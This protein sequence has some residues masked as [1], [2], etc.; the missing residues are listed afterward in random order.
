MGFQLSLW[1]T[2]HKAE[3][4]RPPRE[5]AQ[6]IAYATLRASR[7]RLGAQAWQTSSSSPSKPAG[8]GPEK[9][10]PT[11]YVEELGFGLLSILGSCCES[12]SRFVST[13][14][15]RAHG[16]RSLVRG[17]AT[18]ASRP[19]HTP[20]RRPAAPG[21]ARS[22]SSARSIMVLAALPRPAHR[23]RGLHIDND[24]V[25]RSIR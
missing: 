24:G 7:H 21:R 5:A 9:Q 17:P 13:C 20:S 11:D 2:D 23:G 12:R 4:L 22:R 18:P 19:N 6:I 8:A 16:A 3:T 1:V 15:T 25:V 14:R 10:G